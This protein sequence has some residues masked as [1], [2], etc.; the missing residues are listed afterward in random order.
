MTAQRRA[1]WEALDPVAPPTRSHLRR[2][3]RETRDQRARIVQCVQAPQA[4]ALC[5]SPRE[6][7][8]SEVTDGLQQR[9]VHRAVRAG[10]TFDH[11]ALDEARE[12]AGHIVGAESLVGADRLRV[13]EAEV[14]GE[15]RQ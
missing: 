10:S 11:R 6:P 5:T 13:G 2:A 4:L 15:Y 8:G 3:G 9:V 7:R 1:D 14:A 12:P